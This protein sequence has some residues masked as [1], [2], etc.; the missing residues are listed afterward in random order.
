MIID[1]KSIIKSV[2]TGSRLIV[3]CGCSSHKKVPEA[4]GIDKQDF[5]CV[6]IVGDIMEV[7]G[8]LPDASIRTLYAFH[9]V[10]HLLDLTIFMSELERT[11]EVGGTLHFVAPH[12][13]NPY[14]YSDPTHRTFFGLYTFCYFS[15]SSLFKRQVP[16][17]RTNL[18]W[19][20]ESVGLKFKSTPPFYVR[21]C[22]KTAVGVLFNSST[23]LKEF[24]EENLC[25]VFPCYEVE[26]VLRRIPS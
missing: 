10:E 3:E 26:Y 9:L 1:K 20:L 15:E 7:L 16:N 12:F 4:L 22:V 14:F 25:Q 24:Y 21:H 13:S 19:R 8:S 17:Y 5:P 6:D 18:C 2:T 11:V 23:W